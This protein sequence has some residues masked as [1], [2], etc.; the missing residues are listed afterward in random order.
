MSIDRASVTAQRQHSVCTRGLGFL[1]VGYSALTGTEIS[2]PLPLPQTTQIIPG[3]TVV[4]AGT[5]GDVWSYTVP[6][7]T[8]VFPVTP[9]ATAAPNPPAN[10]LVFTTVVV[11]GTTVTGGMETGVPWSYT[12]PTA[13]FPSSVIAPS[14]L[15]PTQSSVSSDIDANLYPNF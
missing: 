5:T 13:T 11:S 2:S 12:I 4:G 14:P 9:S 7:A 3:T 6:D 10:T 1:L 8:S 15:A